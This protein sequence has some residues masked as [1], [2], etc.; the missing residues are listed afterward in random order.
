MDSLQILLN[1]NKIDV[2]GK[3]TAE[4]CSHTHKR[5]KQDCKPRIWRK[6]SQKHLKKIEVVS[7]A[8]AGYSQLVLTS[9]LCLAQKRMATVWASDRQS[10]GTSVLFSNIALRMWH[11]VCCPASSREGAWLQTPA[12]AS[13]PWAFF[14]KGR[15]QQDYFL[16]K[17]LNKKSKSTEKI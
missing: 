10:P 13:V 6:S 12:N 15:G 14:G 8:L 5:L 1:S 2:I 11:W 4:D 16:N 3:K 7:I 17:N 9:A